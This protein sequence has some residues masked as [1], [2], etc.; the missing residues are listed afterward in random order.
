VARRNSL[1]I[2]AIVFCLALILVG[3]SRSDVFLSTFNIG[4]V[5]VQ[6]TALLLVS[7]GQTYA[8]GSG[9]LDLS[10]GSV[11]SLAA[12]VTAVSFEPLGVPLAVALGILS[13]VAIG[14]INGV[15]VASGV[16]PFLV[17]LA[18]LSVAQGIALFVSPVPGGKVPAGYATIASFWG[19]VPV[20]L[21]FVLLIAAW[22]GW[23]VK[24][25]RVG[26]NIV[27]VGGNAEVARLCG[28][29][30]KRT[31]IWA[32]VLSAGMAVLAG[33]FLVARTRTGDPTIGARFTLDSLAAV[34]L[35]GT[36]LG[37]GRVT[38]LGTVVGAVALGLLSNV[39]NLLQVP[40][41]YQTPVK[42]LL[43]IGAVLLPNIISR[44]VEHRR[45]VQAAAELQHEPNNHARGNYG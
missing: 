14:L 45:A 2:P 43:V 10:V 40:A 12:V 27:S 39:L 36:V 23:S 5:V 6:V 13:G 9:G 21:P 33:L 34:V 16:E 20:A 35:G 38:M 31:Y 15:V 44:I 8:V 18:N 41:F 30:V 37:G 4:N 7:I 25:S 22:A 11:V 32:Y 3:V 26:S 29:P 42:G 19:A 17:T 28:V 24:R 1:A